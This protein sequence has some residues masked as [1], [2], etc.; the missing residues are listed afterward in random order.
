MGST[1]IK[2]KKMSI[3]QLKEL[4]EQYR[5][6]R[7]EE[8]VYRM[9]LSATNGKHVVCN[10]EVLNKIVDLLISESQQQIEKEVKG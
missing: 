1:C 2:N 10:R 7:N 8:V 4:N 5:K 6:L 9:E 3:K